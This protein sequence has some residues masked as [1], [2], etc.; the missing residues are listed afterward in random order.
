MYK[1][2][3]VLDEIEVYRPAIEEYKINDAMYEGSA[4]KEFHRLNTLKELLEQGFTVEDY[5]SGQ[6]LVNHEYVVGLLNRKWQHKSR[7][8][9]RWYPFNSAQSLSRYFLDY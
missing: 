5:A 6:V 7:L 3:Q 9:K 4:C 2:E 8:N 1:L